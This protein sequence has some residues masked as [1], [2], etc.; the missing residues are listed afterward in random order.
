MPFIF[1]ESIACK[2]S[3][4]MAT[5]SPN[6]VVTRA[7]EIPDESDLASPVPKILISLKV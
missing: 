7:S 6:S 1:L 4:G 3:A 2:M 5:T